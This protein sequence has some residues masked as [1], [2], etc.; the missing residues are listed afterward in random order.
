MK[1]QMHLDKS[2]KQFVT[3]IFDFHKYKEI[4]ACGWI[5]LPY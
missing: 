1:D 5:Y 2:R 4:S 3:I